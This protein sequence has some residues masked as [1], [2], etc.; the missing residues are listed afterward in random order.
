MRIMDWSSDVCSSDLLA[1]VSTG[2][3]PIGD[4]GAILLERAERNHAEIEHRRR[5]DEAQFKPGHFQYS[6]LLTGRARRG[7]ASVVRR[8][9]L[10]PFADTEGLRDFVIGRAM[11]GT[12]CEPCFEL[13]AARIGIRAAH[14]R[15]PFSGLVPQI[16]GPLWRIII[17]VHSRSRAA[18]MWARAR[19][20]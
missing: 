14:D 12:S 19:A 16:T 2:G 15:K 7:R 4:V 3:A 8:I 17:F 9:L 1:R 5:A 20:T 13:F 11:Q 6:G 10:Q 18:S